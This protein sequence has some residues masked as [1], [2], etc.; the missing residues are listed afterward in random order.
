MT[1][2]FSTHFRRPIA[3]LT[4]LS[5]VVGLFMITPATTSAQSADPAPSYLASFDAC[6]EDVIPDADFADVPARHDN[7]ADIDCIA[8]YGITKGT[9]A[10]TYSPDAPVIREHMALFLV[11]MAR[12]V[13]IDVPSAG[14]TPFTDISDLSAASR[15]AI[16][17]IYQLGITIGATATTY[18]P[19]R[20]VN[21]GEMALFLQRLMD[22]M[23]PVAD[24][25]DAFG[26]TPDDVDRNSQN[27]DILSPF[28]DL[29]NVIHS[30]NDAVTHLYELGVASGLSSRIYG[31]A[32]DMS[33]SAM[34]EFMAAILD[35]SNLRPEGVMVQVTP[36]QGSEDFE[37]TVLISVRSDT[38]VPSANR[39]VDWFYTD[40]ADGGLQNNGTCDDAVIL[41]SGD[42]EWDEDDDDSTDRDG[43][44]FEEFDATPGATMSV[45]AWIGRRDGDVFD[46]DNV[47][48]SKAQATS[49]KDAD[50]LSVTH[51]VPTNAARIGGDGAYI[52]DMDRRSSV[53]FTIEL[54]NENG[55]RLEREG[56]EIEIEVESR[57]VRLD[58]DEVSSGN[59]PMPDPDLVSIGRDST[60]D[61]VVTTDRRGRAVF[62]LDG[63]S[64][65]ERLD[66]V[67]IDSDCC[68]N[69]R[70][71]I[72]WSESDS[73]LVSVKPDFKLY[74]QRSGINI[75]FTVEYDLYDQYG[76]PLR[77][78]SDRYTGRTDTDLT[79]KLEYRLFDVS[80]PGAGATA[81]TIVESSLT[82]GSAGMET[83]DISRRSLTAD[84]E[85]EIPADD[86]TGK[87]FLV[88][89]KPQIFSDKGGDTANDA[90]D[91]GEIRYV[92]SEVVVWIV[93]D[94][95]DEDEFETVKN[96]TFP[97]SVSGIESDLPQVQLY[98]SD[99]KFRTFFTLWSYRSG[100]RFQVGGDEVSISRFE[101]ELEQVSD[102]GDFNVLLYGPATDSFRFFVI[103]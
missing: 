80:P 25:R 78:T 48:F 51:D 4:G 45:Y 69:E 16:S 54:L 17:Q 29:D 10:T 56:V 22:L 11:R 75:E 85:I 3:L 62:E 53:E 76:E 49:V 50:S 19:A 18:A 34:A 72:A 103:N 57:E 98:A 83:M 77:G 33:R 97:G 71:E 100:D 73:V 92:D 46:D 90:L 28:R 23:E 39:V 60:D 37:I 101:E 64:R 81:Y 68:A 40:D 52:V 87:D 91:D 47:D 15:E 44:I 35:H 32:T 59:D 82:S 26:Y 63:P 21:R 2:H 8:Y 31:P 5:L 89:V 30:V 14:N 36:T 1:T 79:A 42:C 88:V 41:G 93:S 13:G 102:I 84:V 43:N 99:S 94:A 24:G 95:N 96:R 27:F 70:F 58:A 7:A 74:Q 20:N 55:V 61:S 65:N 38:F 12:L 67:T 86:R 9:S 6:P 66:T